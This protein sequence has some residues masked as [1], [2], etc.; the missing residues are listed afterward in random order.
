L[1]E[2]LLIDHDNW[3]SE[4]ILKAIDNEK[5]RVVS[6]NTDVYVHLLYWTAWIDEKG[7]LNF[8][9]DIY[10]RDDPLNAALLERPPR[11]FR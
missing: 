9:E 5:R 10:N 7:N 8:R 3:T 11:S 6:L 4:A 2:Y 1:A